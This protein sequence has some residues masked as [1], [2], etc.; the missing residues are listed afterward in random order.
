M[1][2]SGMGT[3][4]KPA[5]LELEGKEAQRPL[6]TTGKQHLSQPWL[7]QEETTPWSR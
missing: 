2:K 5:Q 1:T 3:N 4:Y 6:E 7:S